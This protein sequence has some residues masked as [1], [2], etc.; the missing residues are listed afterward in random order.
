MSAIAEFEQQDWVKALSQGKQSSSSK[1]KYVDPNMVFPFQD[2][3]STGT[4]HSANVTPANSRNASAASK[5]IK[6]ADDDDNI[7]VLTSKSLAENGN[8]PPMEENRSEQVVG[9]RVA[10]GSDQKPVSGPTANAITA[11][12]EG[13]SPNPQRRIQGSYK[14]RH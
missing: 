10:S 1:K 9:N 5:M 14:H 11:R 6:N 4:I 8:L 12:A 13:D 7:S 2:D 3:F